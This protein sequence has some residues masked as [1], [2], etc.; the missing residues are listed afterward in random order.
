MVFYRIYQRF[1]NLVRGEKNMKKIDDFTVTFET[2]NEVKE[3]VEA[4]RENMRNHENNKSEAVKKMFAMLD[5][6][7]DIM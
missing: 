1:Y 7:L 3:V 6:M 5:N 4:L 2:K